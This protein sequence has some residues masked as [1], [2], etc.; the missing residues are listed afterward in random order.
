M[1]LAHLFVNVPRPGDGEGIFNLREKLLQIYLLKGRSI[2][3]SD[4]P[5]YKGSKLMD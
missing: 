5:K 4:L 3:F 2:L 1:L